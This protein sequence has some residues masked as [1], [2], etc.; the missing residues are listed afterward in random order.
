MR[1]AGY[2]PYKTA[3]PR[4]RVVDGARSRSPARYDKVT[5]SKT[6]TR[7][8]SRSLKKVR[9]TRRK[10]AMRKME[11][12]EMIDYGDAYRTPDSYYV[13]DSRHG[14]VYTCPPPKHNLMHVNED[15]T[16]GGTTFKTPSPPGMCN[17]FN[18]SCKRTPISSYYTRIIP[19]DHKNK[20]FV[21]GAIQDACFKGYYD[22]RSLKSKIDLNRK[23]SSWDPVSCYN[24]CWAITVGLI[25]LAVLIWLILM[26]LNWT[27]FKANWRWWLFW[28]AVIFAILICFCCIFKAGANSRAK[29][30]FQRIDEACQDINKRNLYGTGTAVYPGEDAAWLEVEMDPRRTV[31]G[32]PIRHDAMSYNMD[33][34]PNLGKRIVKVPARAPQTTT[35]IEETVVR[36]GNGS[37]SDIS[38]GGSMERN[39]FNN[40]ENIMLHGSRPP[41]QMNESSVM[42]NSG[43]E[44]LSNNDSVYQSNYSRGP[45]PNARASYASSENKGNSAKKMSFYERLRQSKAGNSGYSGFNSGF[46]SGNSNINSFANPVSGATR[47]VN[48]NSYARS[49]SN[50]PR[51]KGFESTGAPLNLMAK[52]PRR[53]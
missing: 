42:M 13:R 44:R 41:S 17:S 40:S 48:D 22:R 3:P 6:V 4:S 28:L 9:K 52:S 29:K 26:I 32:G 8:S 35:V 45:S 30:R 24:Y 34:T 1:S 37:V 14:K 49:N 11:A 15:P 46:Q 47:G 23:Y 21:Y 2:T 10:K 43:Y 12:I 51:A 5:T 39:S 7:G 50:S 25:A 16:L 31:I 18:R 36:S 53:R 20:D 19:W 38:R 27:H 33:N